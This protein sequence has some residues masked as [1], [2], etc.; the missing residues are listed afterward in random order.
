MNNTEPDDG[1]RLDAL[2]RAYLDEETLGIEFSPALLLWLI[3][4]R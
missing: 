4:H 3:T 2:I 1:G